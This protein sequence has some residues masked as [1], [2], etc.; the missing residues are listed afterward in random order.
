[1]YNVYTTELLN[2]LRDMMLHELKLWRPD[3]TQTTGSLPVNQLPPA[4]ISTPGGMS[5]ADKVKLDAYPA[6]AFAVG[7][8]IYASTTS[9]MSRLA[10][11]ATGNALISGGV[12]TAPS[13]GKIGLT[14][15][16]SGTLP[17]ANGGTNITSYAVGDLI[18]A[19]GAT[20]LSK[21]ADVATGNVLISGGVTTAPAWGKVAL[22]THVSGTLPS[23]N[24]GTGVNNAGTLTNA[25]NTTITGGGTLALGGF[26][27]TVPATGTAVLGTGTADRVA[28][29]SGTNTLTS[30]A[31]LTYDGATLTATRGSAQLI[32]AT[33][34]ANVFKS[35]GTT[36]QNVPL[37][38][39]ADGGVIF[40]S[41]P[42]SSMFLLSARL[43]N[44]LWGANMYHDGTNYRG[45]SQ[46]RRSIGLEWSSSST[47]AASAYLRV[48]QAPAPG[49]S[50]GTVTPVELMRIYSG[51]TTF[52]TAATYID[53][54]GSGTFNFGIGDITGGSY[55]QFQ[56]ASATQGLISQFS[57]AGGST[58]DI[59][60]SPA[61]GTSA[62]AFRFFRSTNTSGTV[63]FDVFIGDSSATTNARI[64]ANI[65]S[66]FCANNSQLGIGHSSPS[67]LLDTRL[68]NA[69]TNAT[70]VVQI[71]G[72]N[73]TGTAAANFGAGLK[74]TLESSTTADQDAML[75]EAMWS[76]ATH[77]SRK[78]FAKIHM[79]DTAARECIRFAASG[80][81]AMIGFL[82][83]AAIV[84]PAAYTLTGSA[85]RT[86][87]TD[88]SGAYTGINNAQAGTVYATVADLNTLRAVVS[89]M[90]GVERQHLVDM[91]AGGAGYGLLQ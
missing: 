26:T 86:M 4:T 24:G 40:N 33:T 35:D 84:K 42:N 67:V 15:H 46:F 56:H 22:T 41:A 73:S 80:T 71:I 64:G 89:S 8:I 19:S 52:Y 91:G 58:I 83:A 16:V 57:A 65:D 13:W 87:P 55:F 75:I 81:A 36:L 68:N 76:T 59:N 78:A 85:T 5:A 23:A 48:I 62:A 7:D 72:H 9:V 6:P 44:W 49:A 18:Y 54:G 82:G 70:D 50:G 30:D 21:L 27:L 29:W 63:Y 17:V 47:T 51:Q 90:L 11:V 1:M 3:L 66:Y 38:L 25:T 74:F 45:D 77:A 79:Y 37:K 53:N 31:D 60:P 88:P 12:S 14:T 61:D 69:T 20:T 2:K 28:Y 34:V 43:E 32:A 10:D 39:V